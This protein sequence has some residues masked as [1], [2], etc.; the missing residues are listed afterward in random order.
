MLSLKVSNYMPAI[1]RRNSC[2]YENEKRGHIVQIRLRD[3]VDGLKHGRR[4]ITLSC[5][6]VGDL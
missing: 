4:A 5:R 1:D 6:R 2:S 3:C